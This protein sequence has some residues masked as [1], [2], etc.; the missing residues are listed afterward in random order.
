[1][2]WTFH[3]S[4][5]I[6]HSKCRILHQFYIISIKLVPVYTM[7]NKN[8][9]YGQMLQKLATMWNEP[10]KQELVISDPGS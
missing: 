4:Q 3:S 10:W 6:F 9:T 7:W 1:M 8:W 2:Y 5:F